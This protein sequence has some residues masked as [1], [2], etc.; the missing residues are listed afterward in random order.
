MSSYNNPYG[1]G[2]GNGYMPN[3]GSY[4]AYAPTQPIQTAQPSQP[5]TNKIYV[6]SAEDALSRFASPNTINVFFL[7]DESMIF[8]VTTDIQGKK[9]IRSRKLVDVQPQKQTT[10]DYVTRAE[11]DELKSKLDSAL[12]SQSKSKKVVTDNGTATNEQ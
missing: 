4:N 5:M 9:N 10:A 7:Q 1:I 12:Q 2:Y 6:T 8:E 3:Y 11:F